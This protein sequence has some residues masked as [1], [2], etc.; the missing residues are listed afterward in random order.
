[1]INGK[2]MPIGKI[3]KDIDGEPRNSSIPDIGADEFTPA[4]LDAGVYQ[5]ISPPSLFNADTIEIIVAVV[6]YGIDTINSVI[7][8][9]QINKDTLARKL[10]NRTIASGDTIHVSLGNYIFKRDSIYNILSWSN[11]P[12]NTTDQKKSNDTLRILNKRPAMT[13]IYTIGGS[14]P[15]FPNFKT[16]I[17]ALVNSGMIDSVRFKVRPGTYTEQ[18]LIPPISGAYNRNSIVFESQNQ[19]T[20]SVTLQYNSTKSDTNYV[21]RLMGA[22]GIT[23]RNLKVKAFSTNNNNR[24]FDI[25]QNAENITLTNNIIEGT[26]TNYGSEINALV[27]SGQGANH[28]LHIKNNHIK[29][30]DF[31]IYVYGYNSQPPYGYLNDLEII[32]NK[33]LNPFYYGVYGY[34]LDSVI[35]K[36]NYVFMNKY[37]SSYNVYFERMDQFNI[38]NNTL[39]FPLSYIGLYISNSGNSANYE[40]NL[41]S[42]N[43]LYS[44]NTSNTSYGFYFTT[45]YKTDIVYNS[46]KLENTYSSSSYA[47]YLNGGNKNNLYNNIISHFGSGYSLYINQNTTLDSSNNNNLYSKGS[48]LGYYTGTNASNLSTWQS[49]TGKD[50]MSISVDP[51]FKGISNLHVKEVRLNAAGKPFSRVTLDMDFEVRDTMT[52]DIGA[53]E[54]QLPPNDAGI[55]EILLPKRPFLPDSQYVKVAIKNYGGNTLYVADIHWKLNGVT[56]PT[57]FWSDTVASGDTMHVILGKRFFKRDTLY[58]MIAWSSQPNGTG[59]SIPSNDTAR[60]NNVYPALSGVYTIGG[61]TPDFNTFTDAVNAMKRGGISDSVRFDVRNG[62]YF[63][64]VSIPYIFGANKANSI[65]FQSEQK[66]SSK[67]WLTFTPTSAKPYILQLDSTSGITIRHM[68]LKTTGSTSYNRCIEILGGVKNIKIHDCGLI[69]RRANSTSTLDAMIY[70]TNS[71][72]SEPSALDVSIYNNR[73]INGAMGVYFDY[74]YSNLGNA[75]SYKILNN[76]F[77]DQYYMGIYMQYVNNFTIK[78]NQIFRNITGYSNSYGIYAQYSTKGF[79]I[80]GNNLYNQEYVGVYLYDCDGLSNDSGLIFNNMV[81]CRSNS[82]V[83]GFIIYYPNYLNFSYNNAHVQSTNTSAEAALVYSPSQSV[84][85]NNNFVNSGNG[86]AMYLEGSLTRSNNNNFFTKGTNLAYRS[87]SNL[88]SLA[89]WK[90]NTGLDANSISVDPDYVSTTDLHV[91]NTDL[92]SKG[93]PMKYLT[94]FDIDGALRDTLTPDI[95]ADEFSIPA[96]NDAGVSAYIGPVSPFAAG[97]NKVKIRVKNNGYDSLKSATVNWS[98]N[99]VGQTPRNW[100]GKL[101]TGLT[102]TFTVGSYNFS[103]GKAHTL[104]FWTTNPN[105]VADTINFNDTFTKTNVYPALDG[106]YTV[107]GSLPDYTDINSAIQ[108]LSL[109][110]VIDSVWFKI[111]SGTYSNNVTISPYPGSHPKRP[112]YFES[113]TGDSSDVILRSVSSNPIFTITGADYLKFNKMTFEFTGSSAMGLRISGISKGIGVK[114]CRFRPTGSFG[115]YGVYSSSDADDSTT[116]EQNL[117]E[118]NYYGIYLYGS[119]TG[120]NTEKEAIIKNNLVLNPYY[121][122]IILEYMDGPKITGNTITSSRNNGYP[123]LYIRNSSNQLVVAYNKIHHTAINYSYGITLESH[124]GSSSLRANIYNNF[125]SI[126]GGNSTHYGLN[127]SSV[128]YVNIYFNS[129]NVYG[130]GSNTRNISINSGN[131]LDMRNNIFCNLAGGYAQYLTSSATFTQANYNDIYTT[132]TNLGHLNGTNYTTLA[133]WKS[134][135]TKEANS[136][137]LDPAFTS[138][139][140]LHS[141]LISLDSACLPIA[142]FTDDID[143]ESRNSFRPD[144][145]ADEFTSLPENLGVSQVI[146]PANSCGLDSNSVTLKIFN[147][148]NKPQVNYPLRY[149]I[150]GGSIISVTITDTLKPAKERNYTFS[151]KIALAKNTPYTIQAWTDLSGEKYR[152]NDSTKVT[153]TNYSTPDSVKSIAPGSGATNIDYPFSLSWVPSNGATRYDIYLW[154]VTDSKPTSPNVSNTTQISYQI[155]SGL[156]Y[157]QKY[158]WQVIAKNPV[159]STPGVIGEFTMRFL[160]DLVVE[161]VS[162]PKSAF[163]ST[164]ISVSWKVKNTGNGAASGTWYDYIY[165]SNDAVY[166][167]TDVY[168]GGI[169]NPSGLNASQNYNQSHSVTLPNGISGNYY[170]FVVADRSSNLAEVDNN[171]NSGRD[172]GKMFVT[173]TP[174]PDLVVLSVTR[175][176]KAFSGSPANLTFSVKNKGTGPT[177]N[178]Y[179]I[180]RIFLSTEKVVNNT[181]VNLK[182]ISRTSDLGADS[183]YTVSTSVNIPNFI[184]GKYF[185]VVQTDVDNREY[186]HAAES[187][188]VTG[189]DTIE[190][191]LTP[192]PD[193][194]VENLVTQD[195]AS[196]FEYIPVSYDILNDGGTATGGGFWDQMWLCP[197]STFDKTISHNVSSHVHGNIDSKDTSPVSKNFRVTNGITGTYY[198][199]IVTDYYNQINESNKE[200]N[201]VSGGYKIIIQSPDLIV[202]RVIVNA[203]DSTGS[204]T[205]IKYTIKNQGT[206]D[207]YQGARG[208]SIFMSKSSTWARSQAIAIGNNRYTPGALMSGDTALYVKKVIIPNGYNGNYYFYVLADNQANEVFENSKDNNNIGKSNLMNIALSPYPDLIPA[209]AS[210]PDSA[211]AGQLISLDYKIINQGNAS[212]MPNWFDRVYVSKDSTLAVRWDSVKRVSKLMVKIGNTYSDA[213]NK[214]QLLSSYTRTS[215]LNTSSNYSNTI[216]FNLPNN[217]SMG[218]YYYYIWTDADRT[219]Y[220]HAND[221][222]NL[223]RTEKVFIDGYPPVD[224]RVNCPD[225]TETLNSGSTYSLLYSVTNIGDAKTTVNAWGDGI[226][227]STDSVF[228]TSDILLASVTVN[229]PL[230]KDSTYTMKYALKIPNGLS[231]NYYILVRADREK[232]I[233]DDDTTN[234]W[235]PICKSTGGAK[236]ITINLTPPSDLQITSW[237]VPTTATSGQPMKV[238]LTV[239][240]K[241]S[242]ATVSGNWNDQIYLSTDYI[243]DGTDIFLGEKQ[244]SGNLSVNGSYS[245]SINVTIPINKVGNFIVLI[246]TDGSNLEYEHFNEG[247]NLVSSITTASKAPPADLIVSVIN[248]PDSVISG[249]A[250]DIDWK[251]KNKGSNPASGYL[252]DNIYLSKDSVQ[253]GE[254]LLLG[255]SYYYI[256]LTPNSEIARNM[257]VLVSGIALG[258]YNV[259][260]TTDVMNNIN[261]ANDTNNTE[262]A[263]NKL[264]VSVPILHIGVTT[265][266]TLSDG[267]NIYHRIIIPDTLAGESMIITLKADSING[268]NQIYVRFGGVASGSEF[269]YKYRDPFTGNQ[270]IIIPELLEGTY[271]LLTSGNVSPGNVQNITLHARIMPFEIRKVTP[272]V[273]GNTG[274]VTVLIEGSKLDNTTKYYLLDSMPNIAPVDIGEKTGKGGIGVKP[275]QIIALDPTQAFVTFDLNGFDTGFYNV[276]AVKNDQVATLVKGFQIVQ[277]NAGNLNVSITRPGNMRTGNIASIKILFNNDGNIDLIN[278]KIIITSNTGAPIAFSAEDLVKGYSSLEIIVEE[279]GGPENRLRPGGSGGVDIYTKATNALGF[280]IVK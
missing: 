118:N 219:V 254:D 201:N 132:G 240:N 72:S 44:K 210:W 26:N 60:V 24:V 183:T 105:G 107:G 146:S 106:V 9:A 268:D 191:I 35:F 220:E 42:N 117:F 166:D 159:C 251:I 226:Y 165:L 71:V 250:V 209:I 79:E 88:T 225:L 52:P 197:T 223:K 43:T 204:V 27:Y 167:V 74:G 120:S 104:V 140:D 155:G 18:L 179:W 273:G 217:M 267:E 227:L 97:L 78:N 178:G 229:K 13:G 148:G 90:S 20:T 47:M 128:N 81:H 125:I 53:D 216:H 67:V 65:I 184:S 208:D 259:L 135:T 265:P 189:S 199:F 100:T 137:S 114:N 261:E 253:D 172:T 58:S 2:G 173:L 111:R 275:R 168:L 158:N 45:L 36:N 8:H 127:I 115:G 182:S 205:D 23:F 243:V 29:A 139:T 123:L 164:Q 91:R 147:F 149:R 22:D 152:K 231:G 203:V 174:P 237:D 92:N 161:S 277:G 66:D 187:N 80:S 171:N 129:I 194:I 160:P 206:G 39:V 38:S 190:V 145:G 85:Y 61:A 69:G 249:K 28:N 185:F 222:N 113:Q 7:V 224:L 276:V 200:N 141:N 98:V 50:K 169:Q 175:P 89:A 19:D 54:F 76:V 234:N 235:K 247:N 64:Q 14:A 15:N 1:M 257:N 228:G 34:Y 262:I 96:A 3:N 55:S 255:S 87:G 258:D 177:R 157:G 25:L 108:A 93:R 162:S 82:S 154:K 279:P 188:N 11:L 41:I 68:T 21:V 156:E 256:S 207:D 63:E 73:F 280:T 56:Q 133:A 270:E 119:G 218:N 6:N 70:Q 192:P 278:H 126:A 271:Y 33:I 134:A 193:V 83:S 32:G 142:G 48:I 30:G 198:L 266:D 232:L 95:G 244:H 40:R 180:D 195:T 130:S 176:A 86:Y 233:M 112:V 196:N 272:K 131:N 16:A 263:P 181:S 163:S 77:E 103:S 252:R 212:A 136:V 84:M 215:A 260:V 109:G 17:K 239:E 49:I 238:K 214:A 246:R 213:G 12:N 116:I 10:F 221:T 121:Y 46:I 269:D 151:S 186:E 143:R 274:E 230:E 94:R 248:S 241:G 242:G 153:F 144:I 170:I 57:H 138:S 62:T 75:D 101:K 31:G 202:S 245:D 99:G 236:L 264:N 59:D 211:D 110:G 122:G 5:L 102:D 37:S 124:T 150:N 4:T 51:T